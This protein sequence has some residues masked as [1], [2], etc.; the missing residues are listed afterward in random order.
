VVS[1]PGASS[2]YTH[3]TLSAED[4]LHWLPVQETQRSSYL[5]A[6]RR[7]DTTQD[8]ATT[9]DRARRVLRRE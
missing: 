7:S 1:P 2:R 3:R 6:L 9:A 5:Q 8:I 4:L